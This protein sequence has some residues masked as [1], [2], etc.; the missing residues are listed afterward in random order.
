ME[1]DDVY[2]D[3][4]LSNTIQTN[5]NHRVAVSFMQNQ[6]QAILKNTTGYK[7]SIIRFSLNTETLP[8]F[9]PT[10]QSK[11]ETIYS[12][13]MEINGERFQQYMQFEPQNLAPQD[14]EEYYY[15]YS[16]Q[17]LIYLVNKCFSSCLTELK[18]VASSATSDV[19]PT[20]N[21]DVESQKCYLSFD[22]AYYGY[23]ES[24]KINIYMNYSMYALFASLPACI[25]NKNTLGMDNQINNLISQDH[26]TLLQDYSTVSLWNPVGSVVFTSNLIPIYNSATPPIQVYRNG[27]ATNNSSNANFLNILTDFVADNMDFTPYIQYAPG[28]YRFLSLKHN[29]E[30]RNIDLLVYWMN[31]NTGILKPL[32]IGVGGS[33]SV[34]LFLTKN[35]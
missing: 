15:V 23:N 24:D 20:M 8:V 1:N 13:T 19:P 27:Q 5:A 14:P 17:Y 25:V 4:L 6:S 28:I 33:C 22:A 11:N 18:K 3:L 16:Y 35:Y 10:M 29:A 7:L 21:F 31:K 2:V 12:I 30:I 32:Y 34:K 9:I 26:S